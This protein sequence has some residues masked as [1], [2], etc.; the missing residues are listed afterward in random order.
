MPRSPRIQY[1]NAIYHIMARGDRREP[2][3]FDDTDREMFVRTLGEL[4]AKTGWE[5][6]AWVLMDN[7]YHLAVRTPDANLVEGMTWF[8]NTFTRRINTRHRLWGHLFGG[9]Y[10][11][12]LVENE[13]LSSGSHWSDYLVTLMD[14]LHLNPAR[15]GIVDGTSVSVA[16]YRWSSL[17]QGY[18][19]SPGKR[20]G[21][22]AVREGLDLLGERDE[23]RGRRR[24][25]E[26]LDRWAATERPKEAGWVEKEGQSLQSTLRRGW[27]W[28][29]EEFK[30]R[31]LERFGEEAK[32]KRNR[33]DRSSGLLK[34]HGIRDAER[35]IEE[36]CEHYGISIAEL[37]RKRRGDWTRAS[38]AWRIWK[39]TTVSQ[40]WIA[41]R[42][43]LSSSANASQ[44]I[45]RFD[46]VKEKELPTL[47][48]KWKQL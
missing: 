5:V 47:I 45:R 6:F 28:G 17:A 44:T 15:A 38:V 11:A 41:D 30:E 8:Q 22:L 12:I 18:A 27:Y 19:L 33:D 7:H 26:R 25:V 37:R 4:C 43:N 35:L 2:I 32:K 1:E 48:R 13:E 20:P 42:L 16:D 46:A 23:A 36:A 31:L 14:Y 24:L 34:D 29:T 9:R 3:V 39:E 10:K 21:W 40:S